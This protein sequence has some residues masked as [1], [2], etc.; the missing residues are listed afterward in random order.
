MARISIDDDSPLSHF[1]CQFDSGRYPELVNG[2]VKEWGS[3]TEYEE[4]KAAIAET[5]AL[6]IN[7]LKKWTEMKMSVKGNALVKASG[8][9]ST[10][11]F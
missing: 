3:F 8:E 6:V 11:E 10:I 7:G 2:R 9:N 5:N 4:F 1:I